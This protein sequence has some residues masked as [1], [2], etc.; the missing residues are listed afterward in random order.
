MT[1]VVHDDVL[2]TVEPGD[3]SALLYAAAFDI[4]T[5]TVVGMLLDLATGRETAVAA[6]TN[7]QVSYGDDVV[8]R[9]SFAGADEGLAKLHSAII[10]CINDI[11]AELCSTAGVS[12]V[13]HLRGRPLRQ[14]RDEPPVPRRRSDLRRAGALRG[15][16]ALR[17]RPA[18]VRARY[19]DQRAP[20]A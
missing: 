18:G 7:P 2:L 3:T 9:I 10:G 15:G 8:S 14:H 5:T 1:A 6:R 16:A 13:E 4:G 17:R 11:L 19:R 20:P 12:H